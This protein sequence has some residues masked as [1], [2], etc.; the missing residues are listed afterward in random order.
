MRQL[1]M[2]VLLLAAAGCAEGPSRQQVG[3][4]LIFGGGVVLAAATGGT[5]YN[6]SG[7]ER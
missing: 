3:Q 1:A 4:V 5:F 6:I 2:L 7:L